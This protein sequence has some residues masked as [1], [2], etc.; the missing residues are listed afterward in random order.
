MSPLPVY[1]KFAEQAPP[2]ADFVA[3]WQ[4]A[5]R[6]DLLPAVDDEIE[7]AQ[8]LASD[9]IGAKLT[10][11]ADL[12]A[13]QRVFPASVLVFRESGEV[14]G[15]FAFMLLRPAAVA[16]VREERL[17]P[18]ELDLDLC[19]RQGEAIGGAYSLGF[20]GTTKPAGRA[21]VETACAIARDVLWQVPTF[22]RAVTDIGRHIVVDKLGYRPVRP[23]A[24]LYCIEP[25][26][27]A[28]AAA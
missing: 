1:A 20:A 16:A 11:A 18:L 28:R 21:V 12:Q 3:I 8:R 15:V 2:R 10:A 26:G 23:G 22:T 14:T 19:A 13:L 17:D 4:V 24:E 27:F 6:F 7:Q 9:L 5:R 25:G